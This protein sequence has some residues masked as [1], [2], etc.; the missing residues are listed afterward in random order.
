M[1]VLA[2]SGVQPSLPCKALARM[3]TRI[4]PEDHISGFLFLFLNLLTWGIGSQIIFT[5]QWERDSFYPTVSR[6]SAVLLCDPSGGLSPN[7]EHVPWEGNVPLPL[8]SS[9]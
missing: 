5:L 9:L 4:V 3:V 2:G 8:D 6:H 7:G 1:H